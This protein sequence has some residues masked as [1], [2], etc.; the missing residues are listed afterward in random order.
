[1]ISM[2]KTDIIKNEEE[3]KKIITGVLVGLSTDTKPINDETG[4]GS[5]FIEMDTNKIYFYDADNKKWLKFGGE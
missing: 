3:G 1:M 2:L 4:N 5:M